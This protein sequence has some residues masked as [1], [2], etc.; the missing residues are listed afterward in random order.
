MGSKIPWGQELCF[1]FTLLRNHTLKRKSMGFW[2]Q[3]Q[4]VPSLR[5]F[6]FTKGAEAFSRNQIWKFEFWPSSRPVICP[7]IVCHD[8][9][10]WQVSA[11]PHQP[12]DHEVKQP[13]HVQPFC[14]CT[15]IAFSLSTCN[16][17]VTGDTGSIVDPEDPLEEGMATH[18]SILAWRAP[19]QRS[20][21]ATVHELQSWTWLKRLSTHSINYMIFNTLKQA[22]C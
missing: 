14:T 13:I 22:L 19:R 8:A 1:I 7:M 5:W 20:L 11:A 17:G 3:I 21:M 10:Q 4:M 15:N 6:K 12:H 9:G 18:S 16:E 2:R